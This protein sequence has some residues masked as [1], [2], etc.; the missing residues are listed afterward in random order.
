MIF[1]NTH[2]AIIDE[3]TWN[4]VQRLIETKRRPKKNGAPPCRLSG[5]LLE[6]A[7]DNCRRFRVDNQMLLVVRVAPVAV[8][9]TGIYGAYGIG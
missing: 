8:G 7:P 9:D 6:N 2:E 5:L 3:E 4:N 1:E